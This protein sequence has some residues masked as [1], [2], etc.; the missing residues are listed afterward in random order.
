VGRSHPIGIAMVPLRLA[1]VGSTIRAVARQRHTCADTP[2]WRRSRLVCSF[3]ENNTP[4]DFPHEREPTRSRLPSLQHLPFDLRRGRICI[5]TFSCRSGMGT[6]PGNPSPSLSS[7]AVQHRAASCS[8]ASSPPPP[9]SSFGH[10]FED[11][12]SQFPPVHSTPSQAYVRGT[13]PRRSSPPRIAG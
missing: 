5:S 3:A 8:A 4:I 1:L 11:P 6:W 10:R 9:E 13:S 7:P 12:C 2:P